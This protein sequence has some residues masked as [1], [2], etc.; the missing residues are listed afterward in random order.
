[1][2]PS[3][4]PYKSLQKSIVVAQCQNVC[5]LLQHYLQ[6]LGIESQ[7]LCG[8]T[9]LMSIVHVPHVFLDVEGTIIDNTYMW[10][11]DIDISPKENLKWF[12]P[13]RNETRPLSSYHRAPPNL[14]T[15][16]HLDEVMEDQELL[17]RGSLNKLDQR[18]SVAFNIATAGIEP[19]CMIYDKLMRGHIKRQYGVDV[20]SIE[21]EMKEVCWGCGEKDK[22][23]NRCAKCGV[24]QYCGK[25]CQQRDWDFIHKKLHKVQQK[26][27]KN[28]MQ[29]RFGMTS[30]NMRS[31]NP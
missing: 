1:M 29:G 14:A 4:D 22:P 26:V 21:E 24:A 12:F 18:K 5:V 16:S 9:F 7:A 10:G 15:M 28:R 31:L 2:I 6:C 30:F 8:T 23:L 27:G 17:V 19:G 11:E 13:F 25:E 20:T 3:A